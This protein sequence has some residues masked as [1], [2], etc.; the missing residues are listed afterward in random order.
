MPEKKMYNIFY[1]EFV[2]K[3]FSHTHEHKLHCIAFDEIN[4]ISKLIN[5][6]FIFVFKL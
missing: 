3:K 1:L 2:V 5:C 4:V 6:G